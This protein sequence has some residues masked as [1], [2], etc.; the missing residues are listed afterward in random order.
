MR[1]S[2]EGA[3]RT[4]RNFDIILIKSGHGLPVI[5]DAFLLKFQSLSH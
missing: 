3:Q 4:V 2:K 5:V 1:N